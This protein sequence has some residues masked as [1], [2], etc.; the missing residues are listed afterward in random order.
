[1][2]A[3]IAPGG[4]IASV[5]FFG[6][7]FAN[8]IDND[9]GP[10]G[11]LYIARFNGTIARATFNASSQGLVVS[12]RFLRITEGSIAAFGVRLAVEPVS[13]VTVTVARTGGDA[14]LS[15][16]QGA[17][18]TFTPA[19]WS[20]PQI[21]HVTSAFDPEPAD[22]A[23]TFTVSSSAVTSEDVVV[24][25]TATST[26]PLPAPA[27]FTAAAATMTS[28]A[29]TWT[30]SAGAT[31]YDIE[32]SSTGMNFQPLITVQTTSYTDMTAAASTSYLYRVK[33]RNTSGSS[34]YSNIDLATTVIFVNDP[35]VAQVT[36]IQAVH[37]TQNRQAVNAV[38]A[39]ASLAP[40]VWTDDPL[41]P[42]VTPVRRVHVQELRS[43]LTPALSALSRPAP[44]FTDPVLTTATAVKVQ[45]VQEL[46]TTVR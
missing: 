18:L 28:V 43:G 3:D 22:H 6:N 21:V 13:D 2:R 15:V 35:L 30:A 31:D 9:I 32:R 20:V 45:H 38:R 25:A 16:T 1:V 11:N 23:A 37:L 27:N 29:L 5:D 40:Q 26:P 8:G 7:G 4:A 17:T 12:R 42:G 14:D 24:R 41:T 36:I 44:T 39:L 10:D 34:V 19:N 33:A 46:R